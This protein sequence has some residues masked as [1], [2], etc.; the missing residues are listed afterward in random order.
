MCFFAILEGMNC[1][2][3]FAFPM[4]VHT[5]F[6][7]NMLSLVNLTGQIIGMNVFSCLW[8]FFLAV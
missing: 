2:E 1:S 6:H 8:V 4:Q 7:T 3:H 5:S